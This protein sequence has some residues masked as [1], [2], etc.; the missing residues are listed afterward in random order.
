MPDFRLHP[1]AGRKPAGLSLTGV[2]ERREHA[3]ALSFLLAGDLST[4]AIPA[5]ETDRVRADNLWQATCFEMF[6]TE[7]GQANY[8]EFNLAPTGNWNVYAFSGYR[9]NMRP[10]ERVPCPLFTARRGPGEFIVQTELDPGNLHR[11]RPPLRVG[12]CAVLK[13]TSERLTYWA[14][15]HPGPRPD[16]HAGSGFCLLLP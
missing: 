8:W 4:L 14:L 12:L 10:E 16:F 3:I 6:W 2:I 5:P 15:A 11:G 13:D 1:F 9:R 7:E